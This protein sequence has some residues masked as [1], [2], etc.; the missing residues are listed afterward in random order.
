MSAN[1]SDLFTSALGG[2]FSGMASKFLGESSTS[3]QLAM[4]ALVPALLGTIAQKGSTTE[5]ANSLLNLINSPNV[6]PEQNERL[7]R[8][9]RHR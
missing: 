2:D 9:V 7:M 5:G 6:N 8:E 4:G 1:L 3:T